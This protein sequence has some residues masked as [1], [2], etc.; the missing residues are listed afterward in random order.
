MFFAGHGIAVPVFVSV[1]EWFLLRFL[2]ASYYIPAYLIFCATYLL[3]PHF[4]RKVIYVLMA[5]IA[6]FLT[7]AAFLRVLLW[8]RGLK[9]FVAVLICMALLIELYGIAVIAGFKGFRFRL[10]SFS[11]KMPRFDLAKL[12][13]FKRDDD[14]EE[15]DEDEE[16]IEEERID[17][18]AKEIKAEPAAAKST[19]E[20]DVYTPEYLSLGLNRLSEPDEQVRF[21]DEEEPVIELEPEVVSEPEQDDEPEE[22]FDDDSEI[23][24]EIEDDEE[25]TPAPKQVRKPSPAPRRKAVKYEIPIENVLEDHGD[26]SNFVVTEETKE[27]ARILLET[28]KEFKIEA[29]I[30]SIKKGPVITMF[31][32]LPAS[33]VNVSKIANLAGNIALNLAAQSVRIVAPIPGKRAVGVEIPNQKRNIVGFRE[34]IAIKNPDLDKAAVPFILGRD[35]E[36]DPQVVDV[37]K[38]PHLL[39]AGTTGSGKSVC[40]NSLISTILYK[41]RPDEVKMILV[42]PK[43]VELKIYN[44]VPHLLTPVITDPKK[45]LQALQ[46]C[47]DEMERRYALLDQLKVRNIEGFNKAIK[48]S[49]FLA[50]PLPYILVVIDEFADLM[51]TSSKQLEPA[52][53][54]LTAKARAVGIHLVLATQRPSVDVITGVIKSNIPSRIAFMVSSYTDSRVILDEPGAEMLLGKGDMLF[55]PS[56]SP[57]LTRIQSAFLSDDEVERLVSEVKKMGEPEYIDDIIFHDDEEE[58]MDLSFGGGSM[59]G[60]ADNDANLMDKALAVVAETGKA[61]ASYLQR[62]LS[63][64]YNRA[65]RLI[66]DMEARGIIGPPNGSK[67]R[68]IIH[69]P[70]KFKD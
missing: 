54:R 4:N 41:K 21:N 23:S 3:L 13:P 42:D 55:K 49:D 34:L 65:A 53:S 52:V 27:D 1:G 38:T 48:T 2:W 35:I 50:D 45:A 40:V 28:L 18:V 60:G 46:Y 36:G 58:S 20:D 32:I 9:Y 15:D 57:N 24:I 47:I 25:E 8:T 26:S 64:G 6:P 17:A 44:D 37:A 31:E 14:E 59:G 22:S 10:P 66:E 33:G 5:T 29:Q 69:L 12:N 11:F 19:E 7:L 43:V 39:I 61:S 56:W 16:F 62:R 30:I 51:L 70:D 63:I 67:P 68:E